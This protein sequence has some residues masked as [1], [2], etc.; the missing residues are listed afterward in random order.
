MSSSPPRTSYFGA[1]GVLSWVTVIRK[2]STTSYGIDLETGLTEAIYKDNVSRKNRSL[3]SQPLI[4]PRK[5]I[6]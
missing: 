2:H 5:G 4:D 3:L 1:M 6:Y